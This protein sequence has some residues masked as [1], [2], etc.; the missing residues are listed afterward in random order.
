MPLER[1]V[2]EV[3]PF[4]TNPSS[5]LKVTI[6][7]KVVFPPNNEPLLGISS[8]PQ[9]FAVQTNWERNADKF[10]S[11]SIGIIAF[12]NTGLQI[13]SLAEMLRLN[14]GKLLAYFYSGVYLKLLLIANTENRIFKCL[15]C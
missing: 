15:I 3:D 14:Q 12:Y 7:G 6:F 13:I 11:F 9:S 8:G 2:L 10:D 4:N 5:Q 1:H